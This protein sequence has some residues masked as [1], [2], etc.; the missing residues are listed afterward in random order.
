MMLR[1]PFIE[2][3][4]S[5]N[6]LTSNSFKKKMAP[7]NIPFDFLFDYLIPLDI[8][9]KH[10]FGMWSVYSNEKILMILRDRKDNPETNG[11]WIATSQQHHKSLKKDLPSLRSISTYKVGFKETEWQI[12][13]VDSNDFEESVRK[14]CELIK[15]N[16]QRIGKGKRN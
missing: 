9:V 8:E 4:R 11:I 3:F 7:D 15:R 6:F 10:M 5:I 16:D 13:P 14:V 1:L 2:R 12:L